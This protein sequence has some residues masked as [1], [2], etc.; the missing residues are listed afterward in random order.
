MGIFCTL[1]GDRPLT[2]TQI[3]TLEEVR[4]DS[5][6]LMMTLNS[7]TLLM[8]EP[9][10]TPGRPH[11]V[12]I[13]GGMGIGVSGWQ[14]A[15]A[16]SRLGGLGVVSG[17]ALDVTFARRLQLGDPG[18][19]LRRAMGRFPY[20]EMVTGVLDR[21]FVEGGKRPDEPYR[22]VPMHSLR[23]PRSLT[24][25]TVIANFVEVSLAK[26]G[27]AGV[28]G[29][30][31]LEKIQLPTLPS[32]FGA[33][34]AGVDYVLVGAGIPRAIPGILDALA[35]GE[36]VKMKLDLA[37][38][39]GAD[40][41]VCH[42]DPAVFCGGPAPSLQRPQFL[43]IISS[44][45][46]ALT[47]ARKSS[48][49][50]DGFIVEGETAG[51][52]NAPP[53]GPMR[54]SAS[55]EPVYG[56]RDRPDLATIAGTGLP[57]WLAGSYGQPGRLAAARALGAAGV[58]VGTA[59]AFCAESGID[60]DLKRRV[61]ARSRAGECTVVT[62]PVASPTG[63]PFKVV[64]LAGTLSEAD[65]YA[66]RERVC[67]LGYLRH[68]YRK[69]D[70]S[71]GFRCPGEPAADYVR[72]GGELAETGGRKCLCNGLTANIGLG[73]IRDGAEPE[74]ALLTAGDDVAGIAGFTR[75]GR[76][77]YSAADVIAAV[78]GAEPEPVPPAGG[79]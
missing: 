2:L 70:G 29:I 56:E 75:D 78:F 21:Y 40:E 9:P 3:K 50:V 15:R 65:V 4:L 19:H 23:P 17:T 61:I 14:L 68:P 74:P 11:P 31:F 1:R 46:L 79:F 77:Q 48:G 10:Q 72:K 30:N 20:Q 7:D 38:N 44:A 73:Q 63:F 37:G 51:G 22:T 52:H 16:V 47:L 49:R 18:G 13:Q 76:D 39:G 6:A 35:R 42:F 45:A 57:F 67:D 24:E 71:L 59:F 32:L 27:H 25:L 64:Q 5:R 8:P 60:A 43:A 28:V 26:E 36:P 33:M 66:A 58:Q 12:L 69:A 62:D 34:L 55:G 53:R 54:L 41:A